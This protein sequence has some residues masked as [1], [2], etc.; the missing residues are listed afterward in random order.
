MVFTD[1]ARDRVAAVPGDNARIRDMRPEA[2]SPGEA[3]ESNLPGIA[4]TATAV[5]FYTSGTT[6]PHKGVL[7]GHANLLSELDR[8]IEMGL[9]E[10]GERLLLPLPLYHFYPFVVGLLTALSYGVGIVFPRSL[11]GPDMRSAMHAGQVTTLL[12]VPRLYRALV[13]G[14]DRRIGERGVLA[15]RLHGALTGVSLFAHRRLSLPVGRVLM[16]PVHRKVAPR[17]RLRASGGAPLDQEHASRLDAFGWTVATG[18]GLTETAPMLSTLPPGDRT[19]AS[20]GQPVAGV[21]LRVAAKHVE[22]PIRAAGSAKSRHAAPMSSAAISACPTRPPKRLPRMAGSRRVSRLS[23]PGRLPAR[24][25]PVVALR[26]DGGR[27]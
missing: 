25:W 17:L 22:G 23:R 5:L 1:E 19:F 13:D 9:V 20:A 11:T 6:G 10:R 4:P 12:G 21:A 26:C 3:S 24:P 8:L 16:R 7:L 27:R 2:P 18:C 14:I 15:R